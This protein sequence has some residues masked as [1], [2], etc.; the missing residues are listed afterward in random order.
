MEVFKVQ[1][2]FATNENE[3]QVLIYNQDRT[4]RWQCGVSEA[5]DVVELLGDELKAYFYGEVVNTK[6]EL[7]G[8]EAP[9]QYW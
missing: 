4:A 5:P 3:Q 8:E 2:S 7:S 6:I 9:E 1:R